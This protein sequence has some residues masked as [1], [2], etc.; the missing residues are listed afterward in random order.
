[1]NKIDMA[2]VRNCCAKLLKHGDSNIGKAIRSLVFCGRKNVGED[3]VSDVL[4]QLNYKEQTD[5]RMASAWMPHWLSN[6]L[7]TDQSAIAS[8]KRFQAART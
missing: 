2:M 6:F 7:V 3:L 5:L 1:M 4:R 8:V